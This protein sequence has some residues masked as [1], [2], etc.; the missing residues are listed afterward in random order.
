MGACNSE[1]GLL[2]QKTPE[3]ATFLHSYLNLPAEGFEI[4]PRRDG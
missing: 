1:G 3:W 4:E 2:K